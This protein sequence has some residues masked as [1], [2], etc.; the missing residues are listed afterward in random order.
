V[1]EHQEQV[2]AEPE[3]EKQAVA[4]PPYASPTLRHLGSV[5]E[6]TLGSAGTAIEVGGTHRT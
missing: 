1:A 6:I 3:R 5:R 2:D 4:K